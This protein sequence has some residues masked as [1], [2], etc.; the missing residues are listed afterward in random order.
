MN[1][2]GS[3]NVIDFASYNSGNMPIVPNNLGC[4]SIVCNHFPKVIHVQGKWV[5]IATS[6]IIPCYIWT[7][8][9]KQCIIMF[10]HQIKS[11]LQKQG[12]PQLQ[13]ATPIALKKANPEI[14]FYLQQLL[15]RCRINMVI[16]YNA[17]PC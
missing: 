14:R 12:A 3:S 1:H 4:A 8:R 9:T 13:R 15:L 16:V 5:L 7:E 2:I 6:D 11:Y 17:E 10:L